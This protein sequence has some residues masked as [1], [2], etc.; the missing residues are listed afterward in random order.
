VWRAVWEAEVLSSAQTASIDIGEDMTVPDDHDDS[1]LASRSRLVVF[2]AGAVRRRDSVA[3][4]LCI[5]AHPL[6]TRFTNISGA[7]IISGA[8][9]LLRRQSGRGH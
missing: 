8:F 2:C 1:Q 3:L 6:H 5:T 7:S 4:S 9:A